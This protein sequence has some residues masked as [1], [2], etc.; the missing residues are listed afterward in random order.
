MLSTNQS[1]QESRVRRRARREGY[2]VHKSRAW[3][4]VPNCDNHGEFMLVDA[5]RNYAVLGVRYDATLD[6]IEA[7]L[8][9][10]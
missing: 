4:H 7:F 6:D 2:I 1:A 5:E 8:T 10:D 3:K 9:D